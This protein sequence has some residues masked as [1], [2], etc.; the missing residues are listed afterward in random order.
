MILASKKDFEKSPISLNSTNGLV[1]QIRDSFEGNN[2]EKSSNLYPSKHFFVDINDFRKRIYKTPG[3]SNLKKLEKY[4]KCVNLNVCKEQDQNFDKK[5]LIPPI[6][7]NNKTRYFG[8]ECPKVGEL[9][10]SKL[11]E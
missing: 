7:C 1:K 6:L 5:K 11:I 4:G 10:R 2:F 9:A 8:F 3:P